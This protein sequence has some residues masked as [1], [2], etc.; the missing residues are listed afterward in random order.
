MELKKRILVIFSIMGF[1]AVS[2]SQVGV[3]T[4]SPANSAQ[5]DI[6]SANK[7]L[8]IPRIS[9]TGTTNQN[10][11][12]GPVINSLLVYNTATVNDVSPGF[13]YWEIDKWVRIMAQSDPEI[14]TSLN[15]DVVNNRLIY[16]DEK[17]I[18]NVL[19]LKGQVG[20]E[21]PQG[22]IG[23]TGATGPQ[24]PQGP[25]GIPGNDGAAGPQGPIGL[26]GEAGPQG[27]PGNDGVTG[28]QGPIGLTGATG[29]QGPIGLTGAIGPQGIPGNDGAIGPQG[30]QG[31]P[32]KDGAIGPA[33][34]QGPIGLM[35]PAGPQGIPGNDGA[36]GPQ[37]PIGLTGATGPQG[38]IGLT[39]AIGPQGIPGND[40]AIGPQGPQGI[41]GND[42]AIGPSGPQG[43]IGL[44][45][46]P[47]PQGIPGNDG[48]VGPTGPQ[49][50]IGLIINGTNTTVAGSGTQLDPYQI[51]TPF[52]ATTVS[53]T[54]LN[55]TLGTTVNGV[56]SSGVPIINT[57]ETSLTGASLTT[58]VNGVASTALDLTPAITSATSVSNA[59][60]ANTSTVTVNGVVSSGAPIVNTNETSIIGTNLITSVNN[61]A[62]TPLDLTPLL[63]FGTTNYLET[64]NGNLLSIVNGVPSIPTSVLITAINGLNSTD[65]KVGL[66]GTLNTS[67]VISTSAI[68]TLAI[69]GL[70]TGGIS[71]NILVV[72]S[73]GVLR[74]ISPTSI[75]A[76]T[77][78][79][80]NSQDNNLST[81][82]N[83][84]TGANV[85]IINTNSLD[86]VNGSQLISNVNGVLSQPVPVLIKAVNGL[87][88]DPFQ[89]GVVELGG[90]LEHQ[91]EIMTNG[92]PF[93]IS[94][95]PPGLPTDNIIVSDPGGMLRTVPRTTAFSTKSPMIIEATTTSP[96]KATSPE[97]D[98]IRY[99][100]L[101]NNEVEVDFLYSA[102]TP[103][104]ANAGNGDYLFTLPNGYQFDSTEHP[105]YTGSIYTGLFHIPFAIRGVQS[106]VLGGD[107]YFSSYGFIIPYSATQFRIGDFLPNNMAINDQYL[108]LMS[109][110]LTIG[111]RFTFV[112]Q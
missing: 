18:T 46:P 57:N 79:S 77:S 44:T 27:I 107:T 81:T 56:V 90:P 97:N 61:V 70:Q 62:S 111:G 84:V 38:P 105:I 108:G 64:I 58:T 52:P 29:P 34:E 99:R 13:Y 86:L 30:P 45:G 26:T 75:G 74:T 2:H 19:Q 23:L 102:V 12:I 43:P 60:T 42:G 69:A 17:G 5:L 80:N 39:G 106:V 41:P 47:G 21:G 95:L 15:Y 28:P 94:G 49:G 68:N 35:G 82:V 88:S 36:T 63:R 89:G 33:G 1:C 7:G 14:L 112:R 109:S 32:G 100:D 31:L 93:M 103:T 110:R 9:L 67:T 59:S 25:Q 16:L 98:F 50:G 8:L 87:T 48:A 20:P 92:Q 101:G 78:V 51:N 10:P 104:G 65:G 66:G 4:L 40:G 83:G 72:N 11:V 3:G 91:T 85:N 73:S 55:N 37:G 6:T 54:S 96:T 71:D 24:G 22:P 76:I 53:N